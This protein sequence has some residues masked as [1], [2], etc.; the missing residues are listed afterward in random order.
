MIALMLQ[1]DNLSK[2]E[3]ISILRENALDLGEDGYDR[4]YG[5]GLLQIN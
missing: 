2:K 5:H 3:V 4:E 1:E